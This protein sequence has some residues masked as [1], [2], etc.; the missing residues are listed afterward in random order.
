MDNTLNRVK[1]ILAK[2][3]GFF[4]DQIKENSRLVNDLHAD[5]LDIVEIVISL[6]NEF[7]IDIPDKMVEEFQTV[8]DIVNYLQKDN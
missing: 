5:S 8:K 2:D 4:E 3:L 6:E 7:Q 1:S